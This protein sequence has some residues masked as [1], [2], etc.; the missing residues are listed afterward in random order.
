[1]TIGIF[2]SNET[3]QAAEPVEVSELYKMLQRYCST[4]PAPRYEMRRPFVRDGWIYATDGR[5]CVR[6]PTSEPDTA[7]SDDEEF[8][9]CA[10][11]FD[12][13]GVEKSR[14]LAISR[15]RVSSG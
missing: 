13:R 9:P 1:M 10:K 11:L 6:V 3:V 14:A 8:P 7:C 4:D 15:L 5:V 2:M 12:E